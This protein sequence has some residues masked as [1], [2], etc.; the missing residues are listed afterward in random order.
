M[1]YVYLLKLDLSIYYPYLLKLIG[2][3][4]VIYANE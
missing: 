3:E 2:D 4:M 1:S